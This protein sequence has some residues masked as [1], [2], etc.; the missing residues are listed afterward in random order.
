MDPA[1]TADAQLAVPGREPVSLSVLASATAVVV[2]AG[3]PQWRPG[4][5]C[6]TVRVVAPGRA[7]GARAGTTSGHAPQ[8]PELQVTPAGSGD[9]QAEAITGKRATT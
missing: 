9:P 8:L 5:H 7:H 4:R 1:G 3:V 6:T 2:G